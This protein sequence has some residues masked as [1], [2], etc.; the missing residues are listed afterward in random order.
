MLSAYCVLGTNLSAE[1]TEV[2]KTDVQ[3]PKS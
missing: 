3:M 1:N 2:N